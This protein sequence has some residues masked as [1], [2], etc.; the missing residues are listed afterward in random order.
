MPRLTIRYTRPQSSGSVG[1][2]GQDEY[3]RRWI[4]SYFRHPVIGEGQLPEF[5][6]A[7][8]TFAHTIEILPVNDTPPKPQECTEF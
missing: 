7:A 6:R 2:T 5:I 3:S 8:N 1:Y 4:G